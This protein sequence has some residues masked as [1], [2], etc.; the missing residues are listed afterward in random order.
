LIA[1]LSTSMETGANIWRT[2]P[3]EQC[4]AV[5]VYDRFIVHFPGD[6]G[7]DLCIRSNQ[8]QGL[9]KHASDLGTLEVIFLE[10]LGCPIL[11][12]AHMPSAS[13]LL[14]DLRRALET[15]AN[16]RQLLEF[17]GEC[18]STL[19][20]MYREQRSEFSDEVVV[21]LKSLTSVQ[22]SL[23]EFVEAVEE[24]A[25]VRTHDDAQEL[26]AR[27]GELKE[28]LSPHFVAKRAEKEFREVVAKAQSLPFAAV[29]AGEADLRHRRVK[30]ESAVQPCQKCGTKM[31]LRESQHGYFWGC[32]T[33]PKCF[34]RRWLSDEESKCLFP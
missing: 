27:F 15:N 28:R 2:I 33:F 5:R 22:D 16:E 3:V 18:L 9:V 19:R 34:G 14:A 25:W 32:S 29:V 12:S 6:L 21:F 26:A 1:T 20:G 13:E 24:K 8:N 4:C 11:V 17:I 23:R 31:V 7:G 10:N 30:L